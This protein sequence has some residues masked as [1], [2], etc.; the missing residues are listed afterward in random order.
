MSALYQLNLPPF[1]W[2]ER[3]P[4]LGNVHV[5][6]ISEYAEVFIQWRGRKASENASELVIL[7]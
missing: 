2:L 5:A 1:I 7:S 3:R 4:F 6:A